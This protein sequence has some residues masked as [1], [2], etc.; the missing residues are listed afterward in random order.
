[1]FLLSRPALISVG[2]GSNVHRLPSLADL[3]AALRTPIVTLSRED[4]GIPREECGLKGSLT[5][6]RKV[7]TLSARR[8]GIKLSLD[9]TYEAIDA[10]IDCIKRCD[11]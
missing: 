3:M 6:V 7:H 8:E 11:E 4:L 9:D 1:M 10:V 5:T 2:T